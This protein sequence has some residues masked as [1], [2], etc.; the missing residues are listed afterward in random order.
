M[1]PTPF[2]LRHG[3][4]GSADKAKVYA[5]KLG[6]PVVAGPTAGQGVVIAET[7]E[8]AAHAI[9]S[10]FGGAFGEAG[11][12]VVSGEFLVSE[13]ASFFVLSDGTHA[14]PLAEKDHKR[15]FDPATRALTP[16]A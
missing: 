1:P 16:A 13:E 9:D 12:E 11:R 14:L 10:M 5:A 6:L 8:Q 4:F 7:A 2:P 15:S 3:R